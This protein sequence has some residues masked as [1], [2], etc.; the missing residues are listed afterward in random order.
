[1]SVDILSSFHFMKRMSHHAYK[2]RVDDYLSFVFRSHFFICIVSSFL[3]I[4]Q[5]QQQKSI[6]SS[7]SRWKCPEGKKRRQSTMCQHLAKYV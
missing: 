5:Q 7:R 1:M 3:L 4:R 6:I 2:A